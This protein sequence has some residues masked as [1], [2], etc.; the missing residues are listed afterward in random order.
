M[1]TLLFLLAAATGFVLVASR[2]PVQ[3]YRFSKSQ[4]RQLCFEAD[5]N[6]TTAR[7][8]WLWA[9]IQVQKSKYLN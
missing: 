9:G 2:K 5:E 6:M 3:S 8:E 4:F 7:F 1:R